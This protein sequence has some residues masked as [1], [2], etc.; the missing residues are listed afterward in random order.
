MYYSCIVSA[1]CGGGR[2]EVNVKP[3]ESISAAIRRKAVR[4]KWKDRV[5]YAYWKGNPYV[6]SSR[7][8]LMKC[9]KSEKID[10]NAR[11]Y[12]QV[13]FTSMWKNYSAFGSLVYSV[14]KFKSHIL[15]QLTSVVG[16]F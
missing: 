14:M 4:I 7:W 5:P 9:N 16:K 6:S 8:D 12:K 2:P 1:Y 15:C 10:W 13:P 11:L 3:W